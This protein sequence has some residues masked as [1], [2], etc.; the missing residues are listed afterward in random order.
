[1]DAGVAVSF[2]EA[3]F[4]A[5]DLGHKDRTDCLVRIANLIHRHPGDTL[6][7]KLMSPKD[8]K[9]MDRLVNRPEVTHDAVLRPHRERTL[10]LMRQTTGVVLVLHDTTELDYSGLSIPEFGP[11][12]SGYH[13]GYLCHNSLAVAF[14]Q[15]EALGL[16]S[17]ILHARVPVPKK[18]TIK[19]KRER[20]SRES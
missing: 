10:T 12:G 18:E 14:E 4:G 20:E 17:Q 13:R 8:Y 3:H 16:V 5:A 2:G 1:M 11:I 6:P 7:H 19:A 15:R 9:A